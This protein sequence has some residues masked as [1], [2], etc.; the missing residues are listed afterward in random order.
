MLLV[1]ADVVATTTSNF[2]PLVHHDG[3]E[4]LYQRKQTLLKLY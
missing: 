4:N 2:Q 3:N 1:V